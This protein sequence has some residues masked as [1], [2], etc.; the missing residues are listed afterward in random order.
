MFKKI[1]LSTLGL[2]LVASNSGIMVPLYIYPTTSGTTCTESAYQKIAT[3]A[4][5]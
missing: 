1:L 2:A 4:I 3:S 5:A